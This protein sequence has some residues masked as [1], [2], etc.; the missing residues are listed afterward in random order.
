MYYLKGN[1]LIESRVKRICADSGSLQRASAGSFDFRTLSR[2][3]SSIAVFNTHPSASPYM[4]C[5]RNSN[6]R[7]S[8]RYS[9]WQ[10][11]VR[12]RYADDAQQPAWFDKLREEMLYRKL[13]ESTESIGEQENMMLSSSLQ[14]HLPQSYFE[15]HTAVNK[16][17]VGRLLPLGWHQIH[18][19]NVPRRKQTLPDG[20]DTLHN[21]GPPF[22][23]RMWAGGSLHVDVGQYYSPDRGLRNGETVVCGERISDVQLRGKENEEKLFVTIERK[24]ANR[25]LFGKAW[26]GELRAMMDPARAKNEAALVETRTLVFMRDESDEEKRA[27]HAAPIRYLPSPENPDFSKSLTPDPALLFRFSALTFNAHAI[28]LDPQYAR[29]V[30]GHKNLL[31]HGPLSLTL[32]LAH[33]EKHLRMGKGPPQ[34]I[35]SIAYRNVAPLYCGEEMRLCLRK[36]SGKEVEES[37]Y[38][39]WV[40]GPTG[41]TA[42]KGTVKAVP[43]PSK[44]IQFF[45]ATNTA[46]SMRESSDTKRTIGKDDNSQSTPKPHTPKIQNERRNARIQVSESNQKSRRARIPQ[47]RNRTLIRQVKSHPAPL[48][49][50]AE[51]PRRPLVRQVVIDTPP[52]TASA[53]SSTARRARIAQRRNRTLVRRVEAPPES[54]AARFMLTPAGHYARERRMQRRM[55]ML[56]SSEYARS[57]IAAQN[58]LLLQRGDGE[59]VQ[60]KRLV[61]RY[62]TTREHRAR[63]PSYARFALRGVRKVDT[64]SGNVRIV[65]TN[66]ALSRER[67]LRYL[68]SMGKLAARLGLDRVSYWVD[69]QQSLVKEAQSAEQEGR[70]TSD[71]P[72]KHMTPE[73]R[74]AAKQLEKEQGREAKLRNKEAQK[75]EVRK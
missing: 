39:I 19:F 28:H 22:T 71:S 62:P 36:K 53:P 68:N 25:K 18:F 61:K 35:E 15:P 24:F 4:Q 7:A 57:V 20:S 75:K 6:V 32:M 11:V 29:E 16:P 40:E 26:R 70:R 67:R 63:I 45:S 38:D 47:R 48:P 64:K 8:A 1:S 9:Q 51:P 27:R 14:Q 50:F 49:R 55:R 12:R 23:R 2:L 72:Y 60:P 52:A 5:L 66:L 10:R 46:P 42:V 69:A 74:K 17:G 59:R 65:S 3:D 30:E 31:V 13:P 21:P 37:V 73:E 41:G 43:I 34:V 56:S 58:R 44:I 54:N 33:M